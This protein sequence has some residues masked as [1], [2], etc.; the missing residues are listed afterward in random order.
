MMPAH[1]SSMAV[2]LQRRMQRPQ[3]H[4]LLQGYPMAPVMNAVSAAYD[5]LAD[6]DPDPT[7]AL[8]VGVLPHT[9]C[10][11]KVKGCGFC[12]FPHDKLDKPLMRR[13]IAQVAREIELVTRHPQLRGRRVEAV[14]VGGGT[15]NLT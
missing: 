12:T 15:A 13:T 2:T 4:R 6:L 11:P 9:F 7:R 3:R 14:Y 1:E 10:N 5:P 8:L